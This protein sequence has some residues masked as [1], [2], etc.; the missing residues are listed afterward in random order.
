MINY[1]ITL[2]FY[3]SHSR[4]FLD[5]VYSSDDLMSILSVA[6]SGMEK[7]KEEMNQ[8]ADTVGKRGME[9]YNALYA[10]VNELVTKLDQYIGQKG[11]ILN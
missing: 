6:Y 3:H 1:F 5:S 8:L 2:S 4:L 7:E 11:R 10:E 9:E